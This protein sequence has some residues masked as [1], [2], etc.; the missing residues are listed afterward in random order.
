MKTTRIR[1]QNHQNASNKAKNAQLTCRAQNR[2][3]KCS[4]RWRNTSVEEIDTFA[5][6][7]MPHEAR[8]SIFGRGVEMLGIDRKVAASVESK[9]TN[10][11][12]LGI[13]Q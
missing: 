13:P 10:G 6:Q 3:G 11:R 1:R 4:G 8:K 12:N 5:L 9:M 7:N 2:I